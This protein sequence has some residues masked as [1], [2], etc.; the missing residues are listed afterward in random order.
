MKIKLTLII[1]LLFVLNG[2]ACAEE[3]PP[4]EREGELGVLMTTG[5]SETESVNGKLKLN[6]SVV[7]WFNQFGLEA[8]YSAEE[9]ENDDGTSDKEKSAEKYQA[10]DKIGYNIDEFNYI[11]T[12]GAYEYDLLSGYYYQVTLSPGYGRWLINTE[13]TKLEFEMGPGYRF[14][15]VRE[16]G[17][18]D[19]DSEAIFRGAGMFSHKITETTVFRQDLSVEI[20]PETTIT[21]SVTALKAQI[22][23]SLAMKTSFTVKH[24]S[25]P[26]ETDGDRAESTDTETAV[27]M[28]YS[29]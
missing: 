7:D 29:F 5:N 1:V 11:F 13:K 17:D 9:K 12:V 25:D 3:K 20:G 24:N 22:V 2:I 23:G 6:Y 4:W 10:S 15:S 28:V 26:P 19:D 14:S 8:L 18:G 21:K 16:P 27:T